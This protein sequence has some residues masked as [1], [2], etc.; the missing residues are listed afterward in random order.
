MKN[1][2][3]SSAIF[4]FGTMVAGW[5]LIARSG[6]VDHLLFPGVYSIILSLFSDLTSSRLYFAVS[7]TVWK[8]AFAFLLATVAGVSVGFLM[9]MIRG[10]GMALGPSLDFLR[11]IPATA[12]LPV[13][14]LFFGFG[15]SAKIALAAFPSALTIAIGCYYGATSANP[16]RVRV[17]KQMGASGLFVFRHV[18]LFEALPS[19]LGAMR[20]ALS[21]SL[22][23]V[24]V[25]ELIIPAGT[26][27]GILIYDAQQA[28][29]SPSMFARIFVA[30]MIGYT[31]NW[32]F[33]VIERNS[34]RWRDSEDQRIAES[35][36]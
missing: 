20:I 34:L 13:V 27:I 1:R 9:A 10:L 31:L 15:A 28:F 23:L 33:I 36:W 29:Q 11:S 17:L 22:V 14:L 12:L 21:L 18:V 35:Q 8:A 16:F 26:G 24:I 19:M 30:G 3:A 4:S 5:E 32:L 6:F 25:G 2:P 7:S